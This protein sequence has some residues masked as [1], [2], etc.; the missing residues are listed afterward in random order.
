MA[1]MAIHTSSILEFNFDAFSATASTS[2]E[3]L[4]FSVLQTY[5]MWIGF[6][7][8]GLAIVRTCV[9]D[10]MHQIPMASFSSHSIFTHHHP[11]TQQQ[12]PNS[13]P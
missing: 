9:N 2:R 10:E 6:G 1:F 3:L 13:L 8:I 5:C 4:H 11:N 7:Y 12:Q